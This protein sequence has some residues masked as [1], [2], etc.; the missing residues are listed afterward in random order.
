[1]VIPVSDNVTFAL[2]YVGSVTGP[3]KSDNSNNSDTNNSTIGATTIENKK[4]A[5]QNN[6]NRR[7]VMATASGYNEPTTAVY[8]VVR[9]WGGHDWQPGSENWEEGQNYTTY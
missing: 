9:R 5:R 2:G 8:Q 1:M 6:S 3:D 4:S 7:T